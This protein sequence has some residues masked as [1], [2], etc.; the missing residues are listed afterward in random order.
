MFSVYSCDEAGVTILIKLNV[1]ISLSINAFHFSSTG[2]C[3]TPALY[4]LEGGQLSSYDIGVAI[5]G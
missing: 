2:R 4:V 3:F 1:G 5:V